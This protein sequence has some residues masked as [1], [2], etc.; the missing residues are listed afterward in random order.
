MDGCYDSFPR[1]PPPPKK[2]E[3]KKKR[4]KKERVRW[5]E[6]GLGSVTTASRTKVCGRRTKEQEEEIKTQ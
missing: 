6:L 4:K 3:R 5:R 1:S 2:R